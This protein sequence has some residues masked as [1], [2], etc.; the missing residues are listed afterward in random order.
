MKKIAV[1]LVALSGLSGCVVYPAGSGHDYRGER[2]RYDVPHRVDQDRDGVSDR[3]DRRP[4]DPRR[5]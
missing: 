3:Y 4:Y 1:V 5:Y 2:Q